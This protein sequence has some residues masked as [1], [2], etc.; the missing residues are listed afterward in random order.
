MRKRA[1]ESIPANTTCSTLPLVIVVMK[2]RQLWRHRCARRHYR[3]VY[4]NRLSIILGT[5]LIHVRDRSGSRHTVGALIDCASQISA[6]TTSCIDRLELT[7]T[8]WTTPVTGLSGV[9]VVDVQG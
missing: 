7:R 1:A 2:I 3:H 4:V 6:L 8:C 9:P 5:A